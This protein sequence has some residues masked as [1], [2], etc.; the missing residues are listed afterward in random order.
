[1]CTGHEFRVVILSVVWTHYSIDKDLTNKCGFYTGKQVLNTA[2]AR[3][4]SLIVNVHIANAS[5]FVKPGSPLDRVA[6]ERGR[7]FY[8]SYEDDRAML[9][10]PD[11]QCMKHGSLNP[12]K[13]RLALTTQ[14]AFSKEVYSLL[15]QLSDVEVHRSI[16][17]SVY[18]LTKEE[19]G[20]F[21]LD[22][23]MTRLKDMNTTM[24]SKMKKDLSVLGKIATELRK[25]QWPNSFLYE[26][27]R[28]KQDKYTMAGSSLVK[29]LMC[30]CNMKRDGQVGPVLVHTAHKQCEWLAKHYHLLECCPLLKRMISIEVIESFNHDRQNFYEC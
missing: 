22:E 25:S 24:F 28:G 17:H 21:L 20:R 3:V 12:C 14:F 2:F 7:T 26:P 6:S 11:N 30:L 16:V 10:L 18:R 4:Q 1:M 15:N 19:A 27:D 9:M 8:I 13:E 23:S 5:Y 29:M